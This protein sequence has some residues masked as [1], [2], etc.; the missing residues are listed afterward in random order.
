MRSQVR[1]LYCPRFFIFT[2]PKSGVLIRVLNFFRLLYPTYCVGCGRF[3]HYI[4]QKCIKHLEPVVIQPH[5]CTQ[6]SAISWHAI[7][8]YQ[9]PLDELIKT[10]KYSEVTPIALQLAQ[11]AYQA[12]PNWSPQICTAVPMHP[13]K[14][15]MRG[16]NQ[17]EL[18][19]Q[20]LALL[21][22]IPYRQLLRKT[23][24]THS[25]ASLDRVKRLEQNQKQLFVPLHNTISKSVLLVDDVITTGTT[26]QSC[27]HVLLGA[28]ARHV[29]CLGLA[30]SLV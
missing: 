9:H 13:A 3:G 26:M 29:F 19:A 4:C 30:H 17:A 16:F 8:A 15:K 2:S 24:L 6:N 12:F 23:H 28:R 14:Q 20:Q 5:F 18:L 21:L 10:M 1:V 7:Y 22:K 11:L 25:Q 27:A